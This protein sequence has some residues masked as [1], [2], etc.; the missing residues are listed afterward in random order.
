MKTSE[1]AQALQRVFDPELGIDIVSLGLVYDIQAQGE[2]AIDVAIT[3]TS[4]SCPM[5]PALF[6]MTETVLRYCY[7]DAEVRIQPVFDPPWDVAMM[8]GPAREQLGLP[9][10]APVSR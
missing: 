7:P 9:E 3:T 10:Q 5:G 8:T 1:I 4:Q 6:D 2:D